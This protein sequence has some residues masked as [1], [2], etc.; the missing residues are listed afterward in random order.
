M[1]PMKTKLKLKMK[2]STRLATVSSREIIGHVLPVSINGAAQEQTRHQSG[3][4]S[5]I[6][7][8]LVRRKML[9]KRRSSETVL[10][11]K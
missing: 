11:L 8:P 7:K 5:S 6:T 1:G 9:A 3:I 10:L 2:I 4:L